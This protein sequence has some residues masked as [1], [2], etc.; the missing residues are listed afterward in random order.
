M[1]IFSN[2][3]SGWGLLFDFKGLKA[4][5]VKFKLG[6]VAD[7]VLVCK[8]WDTLADDDKLYLPF[9]NPLENEILD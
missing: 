2:Q 3:Y 1:F 6:S 7:I 5:T 9:L 4:A 8:F